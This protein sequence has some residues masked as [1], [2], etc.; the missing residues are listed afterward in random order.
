M[1]RQFNEEVYKHPSNLNMSMS[2][3]A[4]SNQDVDLSEKVERRLLKRVIEER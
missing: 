1:R 3:L 4:Y 2:D